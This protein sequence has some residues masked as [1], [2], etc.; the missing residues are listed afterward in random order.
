MVFSCSICLSFFDDSS[1]IF[2]LPCGHI[3]HVTC[4]MQWFERTQSCPQCRKPTTEKKCIKIFP[5]TSEQGTQQDPSQLIQTI[6]GLNLEIR[7]LTKLNHESQAALDKLNSVNLELKVNKEETSAEISRLMSHNSLLKKQVKLLKNVENELQVARTAKEKAEKD[8]LV[9]RNVSKVVDGTFSEADEALKESANCSDINSVLTMCRSLKRELVTSKSRV[10]LLKRS[11]EQEKMNSKRQMA[12]LEKQH[13]I[14]VELLNNHMSNL[15]H[16][17]LQLNK[18]QKEED[19]RAE[20]RHMIFA[21]MI[22]ASSQKSILDSSPPGSCQNSSSVAI[23]KPSTSSTLK[24][25]TSSTLKPSTSST[26]KVSNSNKMKVALRKP[27]DIFGV[28]RLSG[29]SGQT[30]LRKRM[31]ENAV[32]LP[33]DMTYDGFGRTVRAES[34]FKSRPSTSTMPK[35]PKC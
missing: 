9:W 7:K 32:K 19:A 34:C 15:E 18:S 31:Y 35:R 11:I 10:L 22:L 2:C 29:G 8:L 33:D 3:N 25:S 27:G 6:D 5:H 4:T 23:L 17:I 20:K 14:E 1:D 26:L 24:P 30:G 16:E 12:E 13:K 21:D 28:S